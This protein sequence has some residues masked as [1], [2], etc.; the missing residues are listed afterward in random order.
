MLSREALSAACLTA[1]MI[2]SFLEHLPKDE[3]PARWTW[4]LDHELERHFK[5]LEADRDSRAGGDDEPTGPVMNNALVDE[6]LGKR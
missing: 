5:Q 4:H 3:R 6:I 1:A 2:L